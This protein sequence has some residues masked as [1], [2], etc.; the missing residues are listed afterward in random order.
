MPENDIAQSAI[1]LSVE[2]DV[3]P[4]DNIYQDVPTKAKPLHPYLFPFPRKRGK[5]A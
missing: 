4:I 1:H 2:E 5:R 3:I